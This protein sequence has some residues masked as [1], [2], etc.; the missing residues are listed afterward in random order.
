MAELTPPAP[1]LVLDACVMMSG[2]QRRLMLA[3]GGV[4]TP[5]PTT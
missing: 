1:I 3:L 4:T 5:A 2:L